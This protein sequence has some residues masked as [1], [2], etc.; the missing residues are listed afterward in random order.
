MATLEQLREKINKVD[1]AIIQKL[2][3]RRKIALQIGRAKAKLGKPILDPA[4]EAKLLQQYEALAEQHQLDPSWL[5]K[6]FKTIFT[7]SRKQQRQI[8]A[9]HKKP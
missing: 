4:R 5:K 8:Y 1:R 9:E 3:A 7:Y 2:A 6:L